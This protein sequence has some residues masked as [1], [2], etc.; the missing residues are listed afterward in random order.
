[1]H[2]QPLAGQSASEQA[3]PGQSEPGQAT[4][5][6]VK[7]DQ[8]KPEQAKPDQEMAGEANSQVLPQEAGSSEHSEQ[9]QP[10]QAVEQIEFPEPQW[11]VFGRRP[12]K[13]ACFCFAHAKRHSTG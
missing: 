13:Y 2:G 8:V 3:A 6:Q 7:P 1:L 9:A 4:P 11:E 12:G 10:T 5:D